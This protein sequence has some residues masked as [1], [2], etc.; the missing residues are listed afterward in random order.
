MGTWNSRPNVLTP[1]RQS[2]RSKN[3]ARSRSRHLPRPRVETIEPR[4][5]LSPGVVS[6]SRDE[7]HA[8]LLAVRAVPARAPAPL[9]PA[10]FSTVCALGPATQPAETSH[11]VPGQPGTM[12]TVSFTLAARNTPFH[13]EF[14][15]FLVDDPSGRIGKLQPGDRGYAAAALK[16]RQVVFTR[17]Q[18]AGADAD[19]PASRRPLFRHLPDPE[20]HLE[21]VPRP[22]SPERVQ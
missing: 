5:L 6:S 14:G 16:R 15:L 19:P 22:Q 9:S 10:A 18:N 21:G 17:N 4:I 1:R 3:R 8:A 13:D 2:N 20:R 12:T 11:L 7:A